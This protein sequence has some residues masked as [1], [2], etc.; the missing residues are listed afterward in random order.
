[1]PLAS[2]QAFFI[3]LTGENEVSTLCGTSTH[4]DELLTEMYLFTN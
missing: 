1:M 4:T 2:K 3:Q